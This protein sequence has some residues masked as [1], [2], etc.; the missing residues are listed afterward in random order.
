MMLPKK[1]WE[2]WAFLGW[3]LAV[4]PALSQV[5][6]LQP[7]TPPRKPR[8]AP[9]PPQPEELAKVPADAIRLPSGLAYKVLREGKPGETPPLEKD[10][11][12]VYVLG[13]SPSGEV[14]HDSFA[15]GNPQRMAVKHTFAAWRE[16]MRSMVPGEIRR[17]WFP[18]DAVPPNPKTGRREPAIFDVELVDVGRIPDPPR[19]LAEPDPKARR[20]PSGVALLSVSTGKGSRKLGRSDGALVSF[21]CWL[22]DGRAVNSS[23]AEGQPTLFPMSKVMP[24]F[25]DCL[26]GMLIGEKRYCWLPAERNDGFPGAPQGALVFELELLDILDL[27]ALFR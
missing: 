24:G 1:R 13:R 22:T 23:I 6:P 2:T 3:L 7:A 15:Q 18:A 10:V 12:V 17:W 16:A 25:A 14:F 20:L 5:Q 26:E 4:S 9:P 11:V 8:P 21:T 27:E 19:Y